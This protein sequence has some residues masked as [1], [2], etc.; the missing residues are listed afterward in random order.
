MSSLHS[1]DGVHDLSLPDWGPYSKKYFG[2]SHLT[3]RDRG[4]RFD[5][6]VIPAFY[7]RQLGIPDALRP[8]GYLPWSVAPDLSAIYCVYQDPDAV[9]HLYCFVPE[10]EGAIQEY[11]GYTWMLQEVRTMQDTDRYV[12]THQSMAEFMASWA[13]TER[14]SP[15]R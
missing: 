15:P 6:T 7:R 11:G 9:N 13:P 1:L 3:D 5:F 10:Q 8:S 2:I 14:E 12:N 4:L